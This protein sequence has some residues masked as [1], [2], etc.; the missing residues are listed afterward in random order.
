MWMKAGMQRKRVHCEVEDLLILIGGRWKVLLIRQLVQ[1]PCRHGQLLRAMQGITQ[2]I[3]TQRLRELESA[4]LVHRHAFLEGK[5]KV[6]EYSLTEWG[7]EV[8]Q[9][10]EL[11]HQWT[12][13]HHAQ[14]TRCQC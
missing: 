14:I 2:K 8:S 13:T 6:T 3:L 1:G 12:V 7:V 4:G 11:M 5:V 10:V 9:F